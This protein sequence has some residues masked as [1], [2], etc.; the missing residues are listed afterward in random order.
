MGDGLQ[1][2]P[3]TIRIVTDLRYPEEAF[4][5]PLGTYVGDNR[6]GLSFPR[7]VVDVL[8]SRSETGWREMPDENGER[9]TVIK[10][11]R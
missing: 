11:T 5:L 1:Q 3:G 7:A 10:I 2:K 6:G 4:N 9:W 8:A